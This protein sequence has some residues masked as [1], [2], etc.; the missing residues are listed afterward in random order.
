M[1]YTTDG[2]LV[3]HQLDN[4][5]VSTLDDNKSFAMGSES[6]KYN[7]ETNPNY[8]KKTNASKKS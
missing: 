6:L 5:E 4:N 3:N 2:R 8:K 7:P 1:I